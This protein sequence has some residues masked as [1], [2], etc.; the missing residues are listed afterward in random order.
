MNE[1]KE[2]EKVYLHIS[3]GG[4]G[5]SVFE[6]GE[7]RCLFEVR[8]SHFG[9]QTNKMRIWTTTNALRQIG[10]AFIRASQHTFP[11]KPYCCLAEPWPRSSPQDIG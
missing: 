9:Q 10:E 3:N 11:G 8:A 5:L 4:V 6:D 2:L 1:E 7:G